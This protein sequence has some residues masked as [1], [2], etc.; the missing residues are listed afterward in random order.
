MRGMIA[1]HCAVEPNRPAELRRRRGTTHRGEQRGE[2]RSAAAA[3]ARRVKPLRR[4]PLAQSCG[5]QSRTAARELEAA[6]R[7]R[8]RRGRR[9]GWIPKPTEVVMMARLVGGSVRA[10]WLAAFEPESSRRVRIGLIAC[11]EDQIEGSCAASRPSHG[12]APSCVE[13]VLLAP[14]ARRSPAGLEFEP[15]S[16]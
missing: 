15:Y 2:I 16:D 4:P 8:G 13:D 11:K 5:E 1:G 10:G 14:Q 3:A 6:A 12:I 9:E 7:E